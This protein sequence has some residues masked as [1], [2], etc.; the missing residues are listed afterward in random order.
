M[1]SPSQWQVSVQ[2]CRFVQCDPAKS[3]PGFHNALRAVPLGLCRS[4]LLMIWGVASGPCGASPMYRRLSVIR[5]GISYTLMGMTW[6]FWER[7]RKNKHLRP[8]WGP[9]LPTLRVALPACLVKQ[10]G[11][12]KPLW[13]AWFQQLADCFS[14]LNVPLSADVW[15]PWNG[16]THLH[17]GIRDKTRKAGFP[18]RENNLKFHWG[19]S[20]L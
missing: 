10:S 5:A 15:I 8:I 1:V 12:C 7:W 6:D 14:L 11:I 20:S 19:L 2:A 9:G 13:A 18:G 17:S 16:H 3:T 4:R